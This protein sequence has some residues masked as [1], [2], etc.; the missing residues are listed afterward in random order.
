MDRRTFLTRAGV[1][2]AAAALPRPL[3][4][5][6][7]RAPLPHIGLQLYTV[8][9]AMQRDVEATLRAVAQIGYREVE[10]AGYF[11]RTPAALRTLLADICLRPASTHVGF[12]DFER[13]AHDAAE[14]GCDWI[15]IPWTDADQR[16]SLDAL[17]RTAD[18]LNE[19]ARVARD[20]GLRF[21]YHNHDFEFRPVEGRLPFDV[22]LERTDPRLVEFELDLYWVHKAGGDIAHWLA[23][24]RVSMVHV[25]DWGPAPDLAMRDVGGGVADWTSIL[26]DVRRAGATHWFVEHDDPADPM[27]SARN[28]YSH[29]AS[30]NL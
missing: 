29:L 13:A 17:H 2:L 4:A 22:L 3:L 20:A 12:D 15:V 23:T 19:C 11:G 16:N 5:L 30:L 18:R 28:S 9:S 6:R 24:G 27:A 25:K 8:R 10:F 14:L 7:G 21:A 1:A 26:R